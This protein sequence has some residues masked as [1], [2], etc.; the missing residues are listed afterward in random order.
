HKLPDAV[1]D[2]IADR[3]DESVQRPTGVHVGRVRD[4]PNPVQRYVDHLLVATPQPLEG[5]RVAVD[6]A[7]G[8]ASVAAVE[9]YRR[10]GAEVVP[11]H[12][13]PDGININDG[14]GSTHLDSLRAAV[15]EHSVDVGIAH[16]GDAD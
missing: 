5:L 8:A 7:N 15:V 9:A 12:A 6:C 13:E 3:L 11:L 10:A 2:E 14:V 4:L 1:E 16:D